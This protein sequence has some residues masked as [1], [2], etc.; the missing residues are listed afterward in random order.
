MYFP[1]LRGKQFELI[2]IRELVEYKLI[3]KN[4]LP[5]IEPVKLSSTLTKTLELFSQEARFIAP[6]LNPQVGNFLNE[7]KNSDSDKNAEKFVDLL[8]NQYVL[9][10]HITNENTVHELKSLF[11]QGIEKD[12]I[13]L[14]HKNRDY[15]AQYSETFAD[16]ET[17]YNLIPDESVFR[18]TIRHNRVLFNDKFAKKT[19]NSDYINAI[20][21]FF[22]DDHLYFADDGYKGF[23]DYSVIGSDYI[24]SGFAPYAV[25][26]HIVYFDE[27]N[28]LRI[29]HFVSD[30]NDDIKDPAGKFG[31]A[32][33]KLVKWNKEKNLDTYG[34][35]KL[36][37]HYENGTYP[38]LGTVKKLSVM[39]HIELMSDFLNEVY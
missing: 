29:R 33:T 13:I 34:I 27:K 11:E 8:E 2:A 5:I 35:R 39:H 36:M 10:T 25:A 19:R 16:K 20:D 28:N 12:N 23:S 31:E 32:L 38:G 14:I 15:L 30:S 6:I 21:E 18:R 4:I 26:M 9:G 7:I 17:R 22:S 37:E 1:Y 3:G 24:E